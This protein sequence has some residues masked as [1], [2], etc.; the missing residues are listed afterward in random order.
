M[1]KALKK[2]YKL[3][4]AVNRVRLRMNRDRLPPWKPPSHKTRGRLETVPVE[5]PRSGREGNGCGRHRRRN[6]KESV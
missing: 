5:P 4:D 1:C 2:Q 6:R 3:T